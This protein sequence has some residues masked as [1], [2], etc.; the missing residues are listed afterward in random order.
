MMRSK[1]GKNAN[2]AAQKDPTP[3]GEE[4]YRVDRQTLTYPDKLQTTLSGYSCEIINCSLITRTLLA[5]IIVVSKC[6][7]RLQYYILHHLSALLV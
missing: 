4:S 1:G 6:L 2:A 5:V 3:A 7:S